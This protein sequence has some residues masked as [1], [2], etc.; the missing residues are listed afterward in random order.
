MR[1]WLWGNAMSNKY[2]VII[3]GS[4]VSG[5]ICGTK[6]AKD[7]LK[8]LMVEKNNSPGGCVASRK[9]NGYVFDQGA[10][11]FAGCQKGGILYYYLDELG[12]SDMQFIRLNPTER[13]IFPD[14]K[15]EVPQDIENYKSVLSDKYPH[16]SENIENFFEEMIKIARSLSFDSLLAKYKLLTFE[17][18]LKKYFK[19]IKLMSI[20]SAQFRYLGCSPTKLAAT[21]MC[22]MMTSY[23]RGGAYYPKGGM[24]QFPDLVAKKFKE[25]GGDLILKAEIAR[26]NTKNNKVYS[27]E[28]N[29]HEEFIAD[30][31]ISTSDAKNTFFKMLNTVNFDRQYLEKVSK[32]SIGPSFFMIS[33]GVDDVLDLTNKMGWYHF[34]YGLDLY[35][36]QSLYIF[37]PSLLDASVAPPGK[38]L[39]RITAP[40]PRPFNSVEN[41]DSCKKEMRDRILDI[42]G[43]LIP[44]MQDAIECEEI[45]TPKMIADRTYNSQ[46]SICGWEMSVEQVHD[47]RLL[48]ETSM[49]G[50][51]L[52]G[53]WTNPGGGVVSAA[54]SGWIVARKILENA[55]I[56]NNIS[57]SAN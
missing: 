43:K 45:V 47:K 31:I 27:V 49:D 24:Q 37:I 18:L 46:G 34:S 53:H 8:V 35:P 30:K 13:F 9:K 7:G 17:H 40:F 6:L 1:V 21:S 29:D 14:Q 57:A 33:L 54:T 44:G 4:G 16:E 48:H 50:L 36:L 25:Y 39:I 51:Y 26:I 20:L 11:T 28:T 55:R 2:D 56:K 15:I 42:V 19:D 32:M 3:I 5:L 52:A 12:I 10:H 22:L 38:H 23:L 41:W